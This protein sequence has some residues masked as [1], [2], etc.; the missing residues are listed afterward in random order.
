MSAS[1][2]I[3]EEMLLKQFKSVIIVSQGDIVTRGQPDKDK[4]SVL[5]SNILYTLVNGVER[6]KNHPIRRTLDNFY[7]EKR[8]QNL[9]LSIEML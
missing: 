7:P 3:N 9:Q 4:E 2:K 1:A 8:R 6:L 5:Y